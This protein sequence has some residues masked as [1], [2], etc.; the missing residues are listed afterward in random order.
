MISTNTNPDWKGIT[1]QAAKAKVKDKTGEKIKI[2]I[3][4]AY[5][6]TVSLARSFKASANGC[7]NPNTPTTLGPRRRCIV[8][9]TFLSKSVKNATDIKIG[10]ITH[11]I[12][13]INIK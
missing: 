5:G 7:N 4:A 9:M 8:A 10:R 13:K 11:K 2:H 6:I 1:A 12:F 3:L